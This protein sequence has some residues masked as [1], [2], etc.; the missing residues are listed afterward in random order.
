MSQIHDRIFCLLI[1]VIIYTFKSLLNYYYRM[2]TTPSL[3]TGIINFNILHIVFHATKNKSEGILKAGMHNRG[4][5]KSIY[6][7][8]NTKV[9][10]PLNKF[11]YF[12]FPLYFLLLTVIFSFP[13]ISGIS[14]QATYPAGM[15][16]L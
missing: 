15:S 2:P 12:L 7:S 16:I 11:T 8:P 13:H 5:T 10:S 14:K 3:Q 6:Y 1:I 4:Y 9:Y